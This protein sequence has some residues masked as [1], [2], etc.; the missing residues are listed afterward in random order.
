MNDQYGAGGVGGGGM[1]GGMGGGG[2]TVPSSL[3]IGEVFSATFRAL[4]AAIAPILV[5]AVLV[6]VPA[7]FVGFVANVVVFYATRDLIA[8]GSSDPMQTMMISL[9]GLA[10]TLVMLVVLMFT[11]AIGQGSVVY[12]VVE[13]LS[14]RSPGV[15]PALRT[16]F[17]RA[18][19][20]VAL[21]LLLGLGAFVFVMV[22]I[23]PGGVAI[24][25]MPDQPLIGSL[26]MLGGSLAL[27]VVA[28]VAAIYLFAA[29]PAC[30][31]EKLGPL[32]A[33]RRS[34]ELTEGNRLTIF[35]ILL[36]SIVAVVVMACCV[37]GPIQMV[38][39]GGAAAASG[40]DITALQNPLSLP[41][42]IGQIVSIPM[43]VIQFA[44][45]ST[46]TSVVYARLR[47]VRD[48][49]DAQSIASVFA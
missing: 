36:A 38:V 11:Q 41:Q 33:V 5:S 29:S 48:G 44:V 14:G 6:I 2:A 20:V 3:D 31:V 25:L 28:L 22:F 27:L 40:G 1:G 45:M 10:A 8:N 15:G 21:N 43:Q 42:I 49:V 19:S 35:L 12:A 37:M 47:G 13:T 30:V 34:V 16:G 46:L 4:G 23:M 32:A 24:G 39:A 18:L 26:L 7:S 9:L 17:S